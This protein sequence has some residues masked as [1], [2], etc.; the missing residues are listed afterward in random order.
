MSY[1][2]SLFADCSPIGW[3][4]VCR[5]MAFESWVTRGIVIKL[6]SLF[7][8]RNSSAVF[9]LTRLGAASRLGAIM[10]ASIF[11]ISYKGKPSSEL[12][13]FL[14]FRDWF[15]GFGKYG[16][17]ILRKTHT[18]SFFGLVWRRGPTSSR[19]SPFS[20]CF[21]WGLWAL[22]VRTLTAL[23]KLQLNEKRARKTVCLFCFQLQ[24]SANPIQAGEADG[25]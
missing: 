4:S 3:I 16:N 18:K 8:A 19:L 25:E 21:K 17:T 24:Q 23:L 13:I 15:M 10:F 9:S 12:E 22:H 1:F 11:T 6:S 5:K 7:L 14:S 20:L 2:E